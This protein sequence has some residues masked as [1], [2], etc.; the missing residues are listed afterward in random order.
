MSPGPLNAAN[1]ITWTVDGSQIMYVPKGQY[2]LGETEYLMCLDSFWID[3]Y[4][5]TNAQYECFL[6]AT[7]Y[8][9]PVGAG[10]DRQRIV[11]P[12]GK[13]NHPVTHVCWHDAV[14]YCRWAGKRLPSSN[15]WEKAA[16]GV[17]GRAY[18]WGDHWVDGKY[19][20]SAE[21][22]IG[23]TTPV[24]AYPLGV[25]PFGAMD[26]SGNVYE[27]TFSSL[28]DLETSRELGRVLR[29]GCWYE[30]SRGVR[31]TARECIDPIHG[32]DYTGFRCALDEYEVLAYLD[33]SHN[34]CAG[35]ETP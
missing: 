23:T 10:W 16:R 21:A 4:P 34:G 19:C 22:M 8:E 30:T 5:V 17:D 2:L 11:A 24:D 6:D 14:E 27:W 26:M 9:A 15:E 29:G 25:S 1:Q 35:R 7:G 20:N 32:Y 18:P 31:C 28:Y 13:H 12:L 33:R 3:K